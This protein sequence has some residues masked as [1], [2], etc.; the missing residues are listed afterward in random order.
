MDEAIGHL[1]REDGPEGYWVH[2]DVDELDQSIMFA[3]DDPQPDGLSWDELGVSLRMAAAQQAM[4]GM[5]VT[6]YNPDLDGD[7][8]SGRG[9]ADVIVRSLGA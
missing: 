4:V 9:L 2:L 1:T 5:Q 6:I 7:G 8:T 3:V